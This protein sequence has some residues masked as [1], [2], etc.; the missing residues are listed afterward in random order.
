[1]IAMTRFRWAVWFL[2]PLAVFAQTADMPITLGRASVLLPPAAGGSNVV[3]GSSLAPDG[4]VLPAVDLWVAP[5][6]GAAVRRLTRFEGGVFP[7]LGVNSG[8]VTAD[9]SRVAFSVIDTPGRSE[10]VHLMDV[11]TAVDRVVSVY[12][13]GCIQ[14]LCVNCFFACVHTPHVAPDGSLVLYAVR[15]ERPFF[16]VRSDGTGL[17]RLPVYSGTLAPSPQRAISRNGLVVFSS[18]A[19]YGPTFAPVATDVYVM[20]FDGKDIRAVTK[21]GSDSSLFARNA[22]IS[23]DG[24]IVAFESNRDPDTGAAGKTT[25]VYVARTDGTGLKA[26]GPGASPSISAD[27]SRLA[28]TRDGQIYTARSDGTGVMALTAFRTSVAQDPAILED[29]SAVVFSLGPGSGARGAVYAVNTNGSGVH[30]VYAPRSLNLRG[31]VGGV[32]DAAPSPGSL[33]TAYGTNLAEDGITAAH[34]FPLPES[35][36]GVAL[37][38]NGAPVPLLAVTPWQVNAQLPQL[39]PEG[40]AAFQLR[41]AD[42]AQPAPVA[43]DVRNF[44]PRMYT[45]AECKAFYHPSSGLPADDANPA[46][47]GEVLVSFW[48][49]LGRTDPMVAAGVPAPAKPLA[50][51]A[52]PQILIGGQAAKVSFA[53]LTPGFAGLYQVNLALPG[54]LKPGRHSAAWRDESGA[55]RGGCATV[56]VK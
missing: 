53:G 55:L 33:F 41:F 14:P 32:A 17:T 18:A 9:G 13:E 10:E 42:S 23:A 3:F 56:S 6:D 54:G 1:M 47:P 7:G 30:G 40:P 46:E 28:F 43:A 15:A 4:A 45:T 36:G 50:L 5:L 52:E 49:G 19:P 48:T 51:S 37:L 25:Q 35:L 27:G 12:T 39:T 31:V 26:I 22:T 44:S 20:G 11:A 2:P 21:L 8:A 29:G 24:V 34:A 38:V 16:T